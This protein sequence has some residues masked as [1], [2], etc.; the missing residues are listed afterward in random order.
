[1]RCVFSMDLTMTLFLGV[2][3]ELANF[4]GLKVRRAF[5]MRLDVPGRVRTRMD[6]QFRVAST[7]NASL[8]K[9]VTRSYRSH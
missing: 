9:S 8:H 1:M 3:G 2:S 5:R 6:M 7:I 4:K